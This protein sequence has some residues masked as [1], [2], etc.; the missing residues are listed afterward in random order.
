[1]N[2]NVNYK[3]VFVIEALLNTKISFDRYNWDENK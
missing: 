1:M 2:K 3:Y